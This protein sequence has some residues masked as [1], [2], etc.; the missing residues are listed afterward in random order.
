MKLLRFPIVLRGT[1]HTGLLHVE[2]GSPFS[3]CRSKGQ[4][5]GFPAVAATVP[6]PATAEG[7]SSF[8]PL[9]FPFFVGVSA[10]NVW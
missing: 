7:S 2:A 4:D 5:R 3:A 6:T 8:E 1:P 10:V 9:V